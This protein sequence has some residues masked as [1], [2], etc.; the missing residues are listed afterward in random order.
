[1]KTTNCCIECNQD[2]SFHANNEKFVNRIP[3]DNGDVVGWLCADCLEE[4]ER[5]FKENKA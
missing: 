4:I 5:E 1:M 2:T 3:A